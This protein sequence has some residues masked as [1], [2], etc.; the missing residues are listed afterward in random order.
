MAYFRFVRKYHTIGLFSE[1][2]LES[3]HQIMNTD[4]KRYYHLNKQ[5]VTKTKSIMDQQN[6]RKAFIK[7]TINY[8]F[9]PHH[10]PPPQEKNHTNTSL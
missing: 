5:P 1:Q 7:D 3:L 2:A 9:G 6:I 10:P 4:E 8:I